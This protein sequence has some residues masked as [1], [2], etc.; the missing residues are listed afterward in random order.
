M[1]RAILVLSAL[2]VPLGA[3]CEEEDPPALTVVAFRPSNMET[4]VPAD[5]CI[6]ITFANPLDRRSAVGTGNVRL[7]I[8]RAT[9]SVP[10]G[11][12]FE[13]V[14]VPC[15]VNVWE[16]RI[17]L[18]PAS[19]LKEGRVYGVCALDGLRDI[20]GQTLAEPKAFLF[21]TGPSIHMYW[22]P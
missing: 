10:F 9:F 7:V 3:G 6:E 17:V 18:T 8:E 19:P 15:S 12:V 21:S 16:E 14:D 4:N 1:K 13:Y 22:V 2:L 11:P 5:A 20:Y